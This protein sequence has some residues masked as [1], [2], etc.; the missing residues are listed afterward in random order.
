MQSTD[1]LAAEPSESVRKVILVVDDEIDIREVV[2]E[3]L[4]AH[5]YLVV[6][7]DSALNAYSL[8]SNAKFD[9]VLTDIVMPEMSGMALRTL[10]QSNPQTRHIPVVFMSGYA[11][12]LINVREHALKKPFE[13]SEL[14]TVVEFSLLAAIKQQLPDANLAK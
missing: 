13:L 12:E 6:T 7:T 10:V 8:L 4:E 1:V 5:G 2:A 11:P 3:I 14:L 9:L